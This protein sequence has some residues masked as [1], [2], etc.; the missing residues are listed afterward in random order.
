[1]CL[2]AIETKGEPINKTKTA[3]TKD[4]KNARLM[5]FVALRIKKQEM[6]ILAAKTT[7]QVAIILNRLPLNTRLIIKI[8]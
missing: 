3:D 2:K 7:N 4:P 8:L 1:L 5:S 6:E